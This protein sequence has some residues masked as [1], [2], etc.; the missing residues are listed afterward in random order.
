M[1]MQ[2]VRSKK[3]MTFNDKELVH[4]HAEQEE[5]LVDEANFRGVMNAGGANNVLVQGA[6]GA[7][8]GDIQK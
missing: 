6:A 2:I 4:V 1:Q 5:Q 8:H 7:V 3:K